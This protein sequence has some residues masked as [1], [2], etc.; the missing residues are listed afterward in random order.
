MK[1][2]EKQ[3]NNRDTKLVAM[4]VCQKQNDDFIVHSF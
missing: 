2:M 4:V 3:K 1:S